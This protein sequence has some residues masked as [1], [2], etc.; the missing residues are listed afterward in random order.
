MNGGKISPGE[1][2]LQLR[3]LEYQHVH[4]LVL[5]IRLRGR[6]DKS[7]IPEAGQKML[8][9]SMAVVKLAAINQLNRNVHMEEK[10]ETGTNKHESATTEF[11]QDSE[12]KVKELHF[13]KHIDTRILVAPNKAEK[14]SVE[15]FFSKPYVFDQFNFTTSDANNDTLSSVNFFDLSNMPVI[16]SAK[17]AGFLGIRGNL[18]IRLQVNANKWTQGRLL[19]HYQPMAGVLVKESKMRNY[20]LM[21]KTQQMS[22]EIDVAKDTECIMKVPY[23]SPMTY[24]NFIDHTGP[25][26]TVYVTVLSTM[27]SNAVTSL[28]CTLF[29]SIEEAELVGA[30]LPITDVLEAQAREADFTKGRRRR[31]KKNYSRYKDIEEV[32]AKQKGPVEDVLAKVGTAGTIL[33]KV[34]IIGSVAGPVGWA[35]N[36]ASKVAGAFGWSKPVVTNPAISYRPH[37]FPYM[38]NSDIATNDNCMGVLAENKVEVMPGFAGTDADEMDFNYITSIPAWYFT[39][40]WKNSDVPGTNIFQLN[41]SPSTFRELFTQ[42]LQSVASYTPMSFVSSFFQYWRGTIVYHIKIVKTDFHTGRLVFTFSPVSVGSGISINDGSYTYREI[43]DVKERCEFS[44]AV[45]YICTF[46]YKNYNQNT[47]VV[48]LQVLNELNQAS[49]VIDN[50]EV[51][52]FISA[53]DDFEVAVPDRTPGY[54]IYFDPGNPPLEGQAGEDTFDNPEYVTIGNTEERED[55]SHSAARFC[56]GEKIVSF[57]QFWKK[58]CEVYATF[59]PTGPVTQFRPFGIPGYYLYGDNTLVQPPYISELDSWASCYV[60]NRGGKHFSSVPDKGGGWTMYWLDNY[61]NTNPLLTIDSSQPRPTSLVNM[62]DGVARSSYSVKIPMYNKLH[63]RLSRV[64]Y[65][66]IPAPSDSYTDIVTLVS[67]SY[68]SPVKQFHSI[69]DDYD[70]GFFIGVPILLQNPQRSIP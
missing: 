15:S 45:P 47:G 14:D 57:R 25:W 65:G 70:C 40:S 17:G 50:V 61:A 22:V 38:N 33:G 7:Q 19:L 66:T 2:H 69:A 24:Y 27:K 4:Y 29:A 42:N 1:N 6:R 48:T 41:N 9:L 23:T 64:T 68:N 55:E 52:L 67:K 58:Y 44:I 30:A 59:T 8:S 20:N 11:V 32:E 63:A 36:L 28:S 53:G 12:R 43:L 21:T 34:P 16:W 39:Y 51:L 10:A 62:E 13:P 60:L 54:P 37:T 31:T 35:A 26:G 46:P 18:C 3:A 56:V 49:N 5:L